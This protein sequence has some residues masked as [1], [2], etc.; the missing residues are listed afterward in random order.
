MVDQQML[1]I[2][3][4]L[5]QRVSRRRGVRGNA[6]D[7]PVKMG[8]IQKASDVIYIR[9]LAFAPQTIRNCFKQW[10]CLRHLIMAVV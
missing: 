1:S 6:R 9:S 10:N 3:V 8:Q 4:S 2:L 7:K 5:E